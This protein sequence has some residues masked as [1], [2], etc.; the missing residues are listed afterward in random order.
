[1]FPEISP[2]IYCTQNFT[3]INN[4]FLINMQASYN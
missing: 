2:A 4:L 1:M 3:L